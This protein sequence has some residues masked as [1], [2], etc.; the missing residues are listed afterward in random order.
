MAYGV[1]LGKQMEDLEGGIGGGSE[2]GKDRVREDRRRKREENEGKAS[3]TSIR[4]RS[5]A[6]HTTKE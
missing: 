3:I 2:G 6:S 5:R 4:I 1:Y